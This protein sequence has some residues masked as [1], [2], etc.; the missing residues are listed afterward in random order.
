M[1]NLS[2]LSKQKVFIVLTLLASIGALVIAFF[3][4]NLNLGVLSLF[5]VLCSVGSLYLIFKIHHE[6]AEA[7]NICNRLAKG[8]FEARLNHVRERGDVGALLW[9]INDMA[10]R[11]DAFVR[12]SSAA[13]EYVARNQY[14]RRILEDGMNGLLLNG[15]RVINRATET[16]KEKMTGF[17]NVAN[18][19][20]H[21]LKIVVDDINDTVKN[22][23]QMANTMDS[24]ASVSRKESQNAVETSTETSSNVQIIS[25]AAEEMSS[26]V[27]EISQQI[28]HTSRIS[29]QAANESKQVE[30]IMDQLVQTSDRINS[31]V[32]LIEEIAGQTNLLALNATIEAARAGDAGKGFA[33]VANEVKALASQT[34]SA[35]EEIR[36]YISN[37]QNATGSAAKAFKGI[38][39]VISEIKLSATAVAAAIEEQAAASKEIASSALKAAEGTTAMAKNIGEIDQSIGQVALSANDVKGVTNHL[40]KD[41]TANVQ[42]LLDK[43]NVFM[44]ELKKIA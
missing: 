41:V 28:T 40:S 11:M 6:L 31:V 3:S 29:E 38:D 39:K 17:T 4:M 43:M 12:E 27:Q 26:S 22:L 2:S 19:F 10:D 5:S 25:S 32:Q 44:N 1:M 30:K 20:D 21:S 9:S 16:V 24:T 15:S 37:M 42:G 35:T 13:L 36:S 23:G 8:E 18:D 33:V 34:A 7:T 14:F